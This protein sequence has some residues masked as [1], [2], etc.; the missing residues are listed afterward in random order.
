MA[1]AEQG[2]LAPSVIEPPVLY[3]DLL[4]ALNANPDLVEAAYLRWA[5]DCQEVRGQIE[6]KA[7]TSAGIHKINQGNLAAVRIPVPAL[8]TQRTVAA[9]LHGQAGAADRI[10]GHISKELESIR[11]L[12]VALL[13]R[14]FSGEL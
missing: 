9:R 8:E 11:A 4:F 5:W 6:R 3:P 14:A 7:R 2:A 13:R 10:C 1:G 12:S